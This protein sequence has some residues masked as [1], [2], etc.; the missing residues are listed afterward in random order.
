[1]SPVPGPCAA[2]AALSVAGL[3]TDRFVF[4]GFLPAKSG[5]RRK[6]LES[7]RA[8]AR[9]LVFYESVHRVGEVLS[10]LAEVFG[11]TRRACIA[12]ELT[13][14]H[15]TVYPGTLSELGALAKADD[16]LARGEIVIVV[17]GNDDDGP[18][19]SVEALDLLRELARELP[20]G[21][22]AAITARLTGADRKHLY[23][24]LVED[25]KP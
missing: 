14:I 22:A 15:E 6:H 9:T 25:G 10:D 16:D 11:G 2:I 18:R 24:A 1:M 8:E 12:R 21:K 19:E 20:A 3:P 7:L 5:A 23:R 13:K 4:E 17:A